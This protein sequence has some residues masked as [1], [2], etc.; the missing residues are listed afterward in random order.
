MCKKA[1]MGAF[2]VYNDDM[3][4]V[5]ILGTGSL[6]ENQEILYSVR[7]LCDH[8]E[9]LGD[10]YVVGEKPQNLPGLLHY[11]FDDCHDEGWKNTY[12]KVVRACGLENLSEEFLL[13]NDDFFIRSPLIGESYPFY[14]VKGSN[15]GPCG[16]HSFQIHCP[17]RLSKEMFLKMPFDINSKACK[18]WR[19]FY[20]NFYGAPPNFV[21]DNIAIT[22]ENV[23]DFDIQTAGLPFFSCSNSAFLNP[24]FTDWIKTKY[25]T[26]S[27]FEL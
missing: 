8:M 27:R 25:P 5:Y 11:K 15:G 10:I 16:Q 21:D 24:R 22:G 18:S 26:P 13:M 1:P 9:D 17:I 14:S 12:L 7:S 20:A 6:A 19:T 2:L 3:D 23:E 4:V